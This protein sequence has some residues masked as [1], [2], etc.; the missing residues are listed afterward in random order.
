MMRNTDN[1]NRLV[2][3]FGF[4]SFAWV[5]FAPTAK[6]QGTYTANSCNYSDVN[7]VINGPTHVAVNGDT[8]IVPPGTCA[9]TSTLTINVA[10]TLQG[11]GAVSSTSWNGT[12]TSTTGTD[13][14]TITED[15][16][17][18]ATIS[19]FTT[20][21]NPATRITGIFFSQPTGV[22]TTTGQLSI[23]G[24]A[25]NVRID[26]CHFLSVSGDKAITVNGSVVGVADHMFFDAP[27]AVTF[28]VAFYNGAG[29]N[30]G[31]DPNAYGDPSWADGANFG[32]SKFFYVEDSYFNGGGSGD[33]YQG[34][35]GVVRYSTFVNNGG[36][37]GHGTSSGGGRSCR[38][39]EF[40]ML[41]FSY[42]PSHAGAIG[43]LN[44]G[45]MLAW[46]I[47]ASGV[48]NIVGIAMERIL[49]NE[50]L[51]TEEMPAPPNAWGYCGTTY[52]TGTART[53]SGST[54]VT[55][56]GFSTSWPTPFNIIIPGAKCTGAYGHLGDTCAVSSV[57]S[58][59]SL[60][61]AANAGASVSS[62]TY[63]V[64]SP[65]DGGATA[66]GYPCLDGPGRGK[67]DLLN[68]L[69]FTNRLNM[70]TST[71]AWPNQVLS[72]IYAWDN[73]Y[74]PP[75]TGGQGIVVDSTGTLAANRDFY[76]QCGPYGQSGTC[77]GSVGVGQG[78][79]SAIPSTCTAGTDLKTGRS[80]PGVGYWATDQN[81][82]YVCTATNTWTAYY[83]PY[84]YPH[85]L[86]SGAT[87]R[88]V[89]PPT[90]LA[91]TVQ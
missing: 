26:H 47:T 82:L 23:N 48:N 22:K 72:P 32:T 19:L 38:A 60:T 43:H 63:T 5:L 31:I 85:P 41:N 56:T 80:A 50:G 24:T 70:A 61:L 81:T 14:T 79:Y 1:M 10:I 40:Y 18:K 73:T 36:G 15:E 68:G 9:W 89:N 84:T 2:Y 44:G 29:W 39:E 59:T 42:S 58:S 66:H 90:G 64:G 88:N 11:A 74:T 30:G 77:D 16:N 7:A 4:I 51:N 78:L 13:Q 46:G 86:T 25:T 75:G 55:G 45:E 54:A 91:A 8:I 6:A 57:A 3:W 76:Q 33:C 53:T 12:T 20:L 87:T 21:G 67:G 49:Q 27:V 35:R 17:G 69:N 52:G 83:K 34:G 37:Y 28:D 71:M 62:V 65:W